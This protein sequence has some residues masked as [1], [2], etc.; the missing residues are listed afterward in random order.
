MRLTAC[1]PMSIVLVLLTGCGG[2]G[3]SGKVFPTPT[4]TPV[5]QPEPTP[6]EGQGAL[7]VAGL[8]RI[9]LSAIKLTNQRVAKQFTIVE[10]KIIIMHKQCVILPV[11]PILPD[12]MTQRISLPHPIR[13]L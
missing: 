11:T 8:E 1:I 4:P 6:Q 9:P 10:Q 12:V 5:P 2:G 7:A 3:G 13:F